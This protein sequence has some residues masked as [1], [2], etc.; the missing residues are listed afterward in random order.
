MRSTRSRIQNRPSAATVTNEIAGRWGEMTALIDAAAPEVTVLLPVRNGAETLAAAAGSILQQSFE[1]FELLIVDDGSRDRTAAVAAGL[2]RADPRVRLIRQDALGLVAALNRGVSEARAG[3]IARMDADDVADPERLTL[4]VAAM[5][6]RPLVALLGTGWRVVGGDGAVRRVALPPQTDAGL[7]A[8][9]RT[10]NALA[11]PTVMLRREAVRRVGG[12]RPA[13]ERAEDYDL[14]LRLMD[15][16][17]AACLSEVLLDYREHGGQS[18]WRGLEQRILSEM[19]A[20]AAADRRQAGRPDLGGA[21]TPI[22]RARLLQMGLTA[23]EIAAGV[24]GRSM[25]AALDAR[26]AGQW[27]AMRQAAR[28]GLQQPALAPRTRSHFGLLWLQAALRL[29]TRAGARLSPSH[30]GR[31][32]G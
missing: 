31:G 1:A 30:S 24:I 19:G 11:H 10:A 22:D 20:L 8:A 28:L 6:R 16:Y 15:R 4:Q 29:R 21:A 14:W 25:G 27:R 5:A 2:A 7:R 12:Y 9:M 26:A 18:A 32:Q 3:L 23:D 17:E 13:F